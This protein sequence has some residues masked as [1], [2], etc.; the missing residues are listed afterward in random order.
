MWTDR[1]IEAS[2]PDCFYLVQFAIKHTKKANSNQC[3]K[4]YFL[5]FFCTVHCG[6]IVQHKPKK[7][8]I[9]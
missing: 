2:F 9:F 4:I 3:F 5:N 1:L 8:T 6:I 7:R